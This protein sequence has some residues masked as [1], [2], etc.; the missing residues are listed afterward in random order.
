M[1]GPAKKI[2][3]RVKPGYEFQAGD[4]RKLSERIDRLV[5]RL[6]SSHDFSDAVL[7]RISNYSLARTAA[8]IESGFTAALS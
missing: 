1:I 5:G 6:E 4:I 8:G 7:R 2:A 3:S